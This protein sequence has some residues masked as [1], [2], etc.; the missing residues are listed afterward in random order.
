LDALEVSDSE[1]AAQLIDEAAQQAITIQ[2]QAWLHLGRARVAQ[3]N[4]D[5]LEAQREIESAHSL[6]E[7]GLL[8]IDYVEG[9]NIAHSQYLR[10][11]IQRLFLPQVY[12]PT[13]D[14]LLLRLIEET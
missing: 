1:S 9:I 2:D 12:F 14:P 7:H 3:F 5:D 4:G 13:S 6:L 10:A 11:A 8:D